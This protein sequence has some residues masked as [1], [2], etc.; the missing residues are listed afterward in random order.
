MTSPGLF[1]R[2]A[3]AFGS[4]VVAFIT[5][6]V[7]WLVIAGSNAYGAPIALLPTAGLWWFTAAMAALGFARRENYVAAC[8]GQ[9][10]RFVAGMWGER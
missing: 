3:V 8:L 4:A 9:A 1:D 7:V 2:V 10:W 6:G 5:G